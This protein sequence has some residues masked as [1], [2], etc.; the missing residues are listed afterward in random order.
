MQMTLNEVYNIAFHQFVH[1][2]QE[3]MYGLGLYNICRLTWYEPK[4]TS[5]YTFQNEYFV[6]H[7]N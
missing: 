6:L 4:S 7:E 1:V 3:N 2:I 5:L